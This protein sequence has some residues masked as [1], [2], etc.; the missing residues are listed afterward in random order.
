[1]ANT[2]SV[3]NLISKTVMATMQNKC[4]YPRL[5]YKPF[6]G[7]FK[8]EI[9]GY[10]VGNTVRFRKPNYV[11]YR[12]G[13]VAQP[14][15]LTE[16]E[17]SITLAYPVGSDWNPNLLQLTTDM[18]SDTMIAERFVQ[19]AT[20]K[21]ANYVDQTISQAL[22]TSVYNVVGTA[23][24][25]VNSWATFD[26]AKTKLIQL[27]VPEPY[28]S[29]LNPLDRHY[30]QSSMVNF[31]NS[32]M[33][34]KI[35]VKGVLGETSGI[36]CY[37][38]QNI[39][40]HTNGTFAT[41]GT[42]TVATTSTTGSNTIALTGFTAGQTGVLNAGDIIRV[43]GTFALN[44]MSQAPI[45]SST[46]DLQTFIVQQPVNSDGSGNATVT[47]GPVMTFEA[48][49]PRNNISQLPTAGSAV[50]LIGGANATYTNNFLFFEQAILFTSKPY[51]TPRMSNAS[52]SKVRD[53]KT[54]LAFQALEWFDGI[55]FTN[56]IRLDGLFGVKI[57][58][59]YAVRLIG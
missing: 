40:S 51:F 21:M 30:L 28:M 7:D 12:T 10:N 57:Q 17:D 22:N 2:I 56:L 27:G 54:G 13:V 32:N 31:F 29:T 23:G 25:T 55:Q 45:G 26:L 39:Q 49:N 19:P 47:V 59:E 11:N 15:A 42:V 18:D 14:Q 3:V 1:M 53:Q 52:Y 8:E 24:G 35:G 41:S 37:E 48:G 9:N 43:A 34:E 46:S 50:T 36:M 33:N 16:V 6:D 5:A 20:I 58:P 38:D 44:I 4:Q